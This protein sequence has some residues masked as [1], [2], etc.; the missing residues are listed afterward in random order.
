MRRAAAGIAELARDP[1]NVG[2]RR[3]LRVA[4]LADG[5][6]Q[7]RGG[8][9]LDRAPAAARCPLPFAV[10]LVGL[11]A[12]VADLDAPIA[13]IGPAA[14]GPFMGGLLCPEPCRAWLVVAGCVEEPAAT[15]QKHVVMPFHA[16]SVT[17]ML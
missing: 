10:S 14:S 15:P 5:R 7:A 3:A 17:R 16:A 9:S 12:L 4:Q 2:R 1:V 6:A 11:A 8:P 13:R